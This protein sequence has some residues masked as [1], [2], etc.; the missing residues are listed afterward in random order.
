MATFSDKP[1]HLPVLWPFSLRTGLDHSETGAMVGVAFAVSWESWCC[2]CG[3]FSEEVN[4]DFRPRPFQCSR[5]DN[6]TDHLSKDCS[7]LYD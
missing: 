2:R 4:D 1:D 5:I 7:L 6:W 3:R